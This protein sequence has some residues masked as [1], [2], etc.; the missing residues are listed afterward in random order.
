M[1]RV[2]CICNQKGGV[3]KT[4]TAVNVSTCLAM[5]KK[6][7]LLIDI[8]PQ[9]NASTG[10]GVRLSRDEPSI[11]EALIGQVEPSSIVRDVEI[12]GLFL[13]PSSQN[14]IGAEVELVG[15][16]NRETFLLRLIETIGY[17]FD[18]I[19]IDCPP[20]L[21]F[22]TLNALVAAQS[23]IIPIQCEYYAL[24]GVSAL[25]NTIQKVSE[26]FNENL[27]IQGFVLTMFDSRNNIC[28][29]VVSN[30]KQNLVDQVFKTIIPR[31]VRLSEAPSFGKP[32]MIYD[33]QSTG[34]MSYLALTMEILDAEN[35]RSN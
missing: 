23:V 34:A 14:L 21:G 6:R 13:L 32:V 1:S 5:S 8:D 18:Y 22:L 3:G 9:A 30:V 26:I 11:Y 12:E 25:L 17:N 20:S 24:E 33:P 27:F 10:F 16:E 19:L 2:I 4:T 7:T 28:H 31:N 15:L 29:Q 35:K